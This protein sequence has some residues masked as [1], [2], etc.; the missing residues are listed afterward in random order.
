[1]GFPEINLGIMPGAGGTLRA[2]RCIG[3]SAAME[4]IFTG[5]TIRADRALELGLVNQVVSAEELYPQAMA[6]AQMLAQKAPIALQ[7]AKATILTTARMGDEN[8]AMELEI[9]N[10]AALFNTSDQKEGMHAFIEKRK[11]KFTGT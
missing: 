7:T 2:S 8:T 5:K 1:M 6:L 11:A 4:L 9:Q 3:T 10:W